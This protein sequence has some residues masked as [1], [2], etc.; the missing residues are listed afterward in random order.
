[1]FSKEEKMNFYRS[2]IPRLDWFL[3]SEQE[4][5]IARA[6]NNAQVYNGNFLSILTNLAFMESIYRGKRPVFNLVYPI[7]LSIND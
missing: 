2:Q 7:C 6:E 5:L 3:Q 4:E 1:M